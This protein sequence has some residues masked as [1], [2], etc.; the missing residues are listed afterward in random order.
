MWLPTPAYEHIPK[1]W[2]LVGLLFIA[3]GLY[4]GLDIP[5]SFAY[6]AIGIGSCIYGVGVAAVRYKHRRDSK[7]IDNPSKTP[8]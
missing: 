8:E 3:N 6:V 5:V 1:F 2:F 7:D 4:L